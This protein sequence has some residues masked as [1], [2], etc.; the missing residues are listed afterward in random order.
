M[1]KCGQ[2]CKVSKDSISETDVAS[3]ICCEEKK[4]RGGVRC[5]F[6]VSGYNRMNVSVLS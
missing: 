5:D 1:E 3:N 2:I 6:Q 4:K